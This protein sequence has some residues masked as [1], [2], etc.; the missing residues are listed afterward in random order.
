MPTV[1]RKQLCSNLLLPRCETK[2]PSWDLLSPLFRTKFRQQSKRWYHKQGS[3]KII[4]RCPKIWAIKCFFFQ[5]L[6]KDQKQ[7]EQKLQ[8][9][10]SIW[11]FLTISQIVNLCV[12]KEGDECYQNETK[13]TKAYQM[14][15]CRL[16]NKCWLNTT[17]KLFHDGK[18]LHPWK[19]ISTGRQNGHGDNSDH[20]NSSACLISS[21]II[22]MTM[23]IQIID[24]QM[25]CLIGLELL[26]MTMRII[27]IILVYGQNDQQMLCLLGPAPL[28][29]SC[30]RS[31]LTATTWANVIDTDSNWQQELF[32]LIDNM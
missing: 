12:K 20:S 13:N 11:E 18:R 28:S 15:L 2:F 23:I 8:I 5:F 26:I 30:L 24:Q 27:I 3:E 16:C 31:L 1:K 21:M 14:Y 22:I 6:N 10:A 19:K 17:S 25:L 4:G 9:F 32:T 29:I 7:P